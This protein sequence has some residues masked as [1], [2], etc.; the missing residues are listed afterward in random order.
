MRGLIFISLACS[1]VFSSLHAQPAS[2]PLTDRQIDNMVAFV[3]LVGY[4]RY[5]YP[6]EAAAAT[7][8]DDFT[9]QQVALVQEAASSEDLVKVLSNLFV[10]LAPLI[11]V[12]PSNQNHNVIDNVRAIPENATSVTLWVHVPLAEVRQRGY[13][14][15]PGD[16]LQVPIGTPTVPYADDLYLAPLNKQADLAVPHPQSP[17]RVDLGGGVSVAIPLAVYSN[18]SGTLPRE[19]TPEPPP[20]NSP[21]PSARSVRLAAV[22]KL[23]NVIQHFFVYWDVIETDWEQVLRNA[24][25]EAAASSEEDFLTV[26]QHMMASIHDGHSFTTAGSIPGPEPYALPLTWDVAEGQLIVTTLLNDSAPLAVGDVITAINHVPTM[27]AIASRC[28]TISPSGGYGLFHTLLTFSSGKRDQTIT[29]EIKPYSGAAHYSLTLPYSYPIPQTVV[30]I[31]LRR[32]NRPPAAFW[33]TNEVAYL[34][35][36]RLTL[37]EFNRLLPRLVA[38][39]G[40]IIDMRGY[41]DPSENVTISLLSHLTATPLESPP[42]FIPI[43]TQPDHHDITFVDV[44]TTWVTPEAPLLTE[45]IAWLI[46][47]NGTASYAESLM[48]I[49]EGYQLGTIVGTPSAGANGNAVAL[50]LP[51]GYRTQWTGLRV[52]KFDG[53]PLFTVGI[54]PDIPVERTQAGIAAGRDELLEQAFTAI[55]GQPITTMQP[56]ESN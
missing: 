55:S 44:T 50:Q 23:W 15:L 10:P 12:F 52:T 47:G 39:T 25:T 45:N 13:D 4:V 7:D 48:G 2:E 42:F 26:L 53:S 31:D 11:Q 36:T 20:A 28:E 33:L 41:P 9:A 27:Q 30:P 40:I 49:V 5:F 37:G 51:G 17:Y 32:E 6:G 54:T 8:W 29:L 46:N 19:S 56:W 3:R 14:M 21:E 22:A 18:A 34:D 1:L 38:A 35:M 24:L 43:V 16:R